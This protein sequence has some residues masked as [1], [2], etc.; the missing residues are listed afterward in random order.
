MLLSKSMLVKVSMADGNWS[1]S[2]H[3]PRASPSNKKSIVAIDSNAGYGSQLTING[4]LIPVSRGFAKTYLSSGYAWNECILLDGEMSRVTVP[5]SE[6]SQSDL[7]GFLNKYHVVSIAMWDGNW[8]ASIQVPPASQTNNKCIIIV[9][10]QATYATEL[11]I[12]GLLT[13]VLKG[14]VLYFMSDGLR[15]NY[16][17]QLADT[18][19]ERS[20]QAFGVPVTTI[21]GY[22]DPHTEL[23][24]Y[25]YPALHG[26]YGFLYADDSATLTTTD[27]QLW[28][29][30]PTETLR[31]KLDNN[32]IRSTVMNAFH[33]NVAQSSQRRTVTIVCDGKTTAERIIHPAEVPLTYTVNGE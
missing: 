25:V 26:A 29:A 17:T 13:P 21:V 24:S 12:N 19:I 18:S 9:D 32:R 15:W 1:P 3:I 11:T 6:L 14:T 2:I 10:Q 5:N 31:F 28:V 22:Y 4:Q 20:P 16:Y 8:A 30:S 7:T 23:R 27:C 33:I